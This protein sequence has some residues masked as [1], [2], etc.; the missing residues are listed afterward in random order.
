MNSL[1]VKTIIFC[2]T[3]NCRLK[4]TKLI[5]VLA[6]TEKESK[7]ASLEQLEK[8]QLNLKGVNCKPCKSIIDDIK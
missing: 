2:D 3:C 4:R 6:E 7:I 1:R 8:W 5:K